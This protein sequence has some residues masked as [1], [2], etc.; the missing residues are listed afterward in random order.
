MQ[1]RQEEVF[2]IQDRY[3]LFL[4]L[5]RFGF[6]RTGEFRAVLALASW[7]FAMQVQHHVRLL[8]G[9][10]NGVERLPVDDPGVGISSYTSLEVSYLFDSFCSYSGVERD[11]LDKLSRP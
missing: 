8:H 9:S 3:M 2:C 5:Y 7:D 4:A 6:R 11:L 10:E 1:G